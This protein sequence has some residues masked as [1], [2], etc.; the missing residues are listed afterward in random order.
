MSSASFFAA[1]QTEFSQHA[2]ELN[3]LDQAIGDGDHGSTMLRGLEAA[4]GASEARG[5]AFARAA[6]GA[7]GTLFGAVFDQL[8]TVADAPSADA[9]GLADALEHAAARVASIGQ[10]KRGDKSMLDPLAHAVD[11]LRAA[12]NLSLAA[13]ASLLVGLAEEGARA[14]IPMVGRRG[15]ARYVAGGGAGHLD[16]GARSVVL[17]LKAFKT[18]VGGEP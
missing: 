16:P 10:A 4:S 8:E 6:G 5:K 14:T 12:G 2:V 13:A 17:V 3:A 1:L 11:G 18:S 9:K 7:S 15:R